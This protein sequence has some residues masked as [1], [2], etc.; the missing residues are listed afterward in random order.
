MNQWIYLLSNAFIFKSHNHQRIILSLL[1]IVEIVWLNC[2]KF[3]VQALLS[4]RACLKAVQ[5]FKKLLSLIKRN[6]KVMFCFC[7]INETVRSLMKFSYKIS[8]FYFFFL[9]LF[10]FKSFQIKCFTE[11]FQSNLMPGSNGMNGFYGL[12][13][14]DLK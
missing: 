2:W 1:F 11:V 3:S 5:N 9:I 7:S 14:P 8:I 10:E 12:H 6:Q 4:S 13:L